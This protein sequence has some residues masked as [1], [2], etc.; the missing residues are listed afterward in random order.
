MKNSIVYFFLVLVFLANAQDSKPIVKSKPTD[1]KTQTKTSAKPATNTSSKINGTVTDIDGNVYKT[2]KIG[3]QI[4]MAENLKTSRYNNG[5]AI[6]NVMD[7]NE[8]KNLK[9]GAY[10]YYDNFYSNNEIYG[11]LYNWYAV[12]T[13]K[14]APEGWHVPS[15]KE[16]KELVDYLG[17]ENIAGTGSK[18]KVINYWNTPNYGATNSSGF[19][20]LPAGERNYTGIF[21]SIGKLCHFWSSTEVDTSNA[22][23]RRLS[24]YYSNASRVSIYKK[25]G[26][27]VRCIKD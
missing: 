25:L 17:G 23:T 20:G 5:T 6:P 22:W 24:Y 9:T 18:M 12:N 4:W 27:S 21:S 11:K 19:T 7:Y 10:C 26:F 1:V 3:N 13:G 15:D 2:V 8:W 16:W 14:L